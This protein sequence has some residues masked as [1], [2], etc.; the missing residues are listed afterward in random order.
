MKVVGLDF[1][2]QML[3]YATKRE[4]NWSQK[5]SQPYANI[6]WLEADASDLPF[7]DNSFDAAT[8][9]YGLRNVRSLSCLTH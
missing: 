5:Q 6:Q 4:I 8:M 2:A 7:Q 1:A 3:Q 9:G